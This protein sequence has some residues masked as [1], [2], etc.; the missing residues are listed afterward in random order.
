MSKIRTNLRLGSVSVSGPGFERDGLPSVS[1]G[2]SGATFAAT[3]PGED[4]TWYVRENGVVR[5][6]VER[7]GRSVQVT[8]MKVAA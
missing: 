6:A 8:P 2:I 7:R 5:Y 1:V 4:A 3:R